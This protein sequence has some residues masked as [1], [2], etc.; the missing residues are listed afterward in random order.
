MM[1]R[2]LWEWCYIAQAL[3]ERGLLA[4][5]KRGL[6]FA[7]GKEP[8]SA[9]FAELGCLIVA[10]D[11]A[12]DQAEEVGWVRT[13]EHA[14]GLQALLRPDIC[15]PKKFYRQVSFRVVDMNDIPPDLR[16]F[17]FVWSACAFEHL[18]DIP[19]GLRFLV[20]MMECLRPGGVAVHTTE[21]NVNSNDATVSEGDFVLFRRRDLEA[22][23]EELRRAGHHLE[24]DFD[25]GSGPAD[26]TIDRMPFSHNPHLKAEI[27]GHVTTSMGVII[28]RA[29][30]GR[31]SLRLARPLLRPLRA[32]G[33]RVRRLFA[34]R[35]RQSA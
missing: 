34:A 20:N 33:R 23:A 7:V 31:L 19:R 17:D 26:Q 9:L 16:D 3:W 6:G 27:Y 11:Q 15:E 29:A 35:P 12:P 22:A 4:P 18:G 30:S 21:Y 14:S 1:H 32:V 5:G 8:L 2:K 28:T 24:L 10:S 13:N 25:P